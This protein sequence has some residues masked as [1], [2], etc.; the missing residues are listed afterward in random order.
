MPDCFALIP[1]A[2]HGARMGSEVPKQYQDLG[3]KPLMHYAV[4]VL[5]MHRSVKQAFVVLAPQDERF[6]HYDWRAY[7][8]KLEPLYCGGGTRAATVLN[9]LTA[10]ADTVEPDDWV[11]VHDAARPCLT[12][13]LI[14]RLLSELAGDKVGGLLA[15]P[16][17]DTLKRADASQRIT[18]TVPRAGLWQAQT[19]QMFRYRLLLE[20]LRRADISQV[21]DEASAI[22]QLG[23][24]PRLVMGASTNLKVTWPE[25]WCMAKKC[26]KS[27]AYD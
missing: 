4:D 25:D 11:L 8:G 15:V 23:L 12:G 17:A 18:A 27:N 19:P 2:G 20:A 21:T 1:A 6:R 26:L 9:G 7:Q 14:E 13:A 24:Q 3:G 10:M 5:C 22:E 16:V